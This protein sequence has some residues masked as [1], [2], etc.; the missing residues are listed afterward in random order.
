MDEQK[1]AAADGV[2]AFQ[3]VP[4]D[5][6]YR[7][8]SQLIQQADAGERLPSERSIAESIGVSR[9]AVR[10]AFNRLHKEGRI[11][12]KIGSGS[13]VQA[14]HGGAS[15]LS[16]APDVGMIDV[17]ELRSLLEPGIAELA[18]ARAR[19]DDLRKIVQR[20]AAME[21]ASDHTAFKIAGYQFQLAVAEATRNPLIVAVY[22]MLIEAREQLGWHQLQNLSDTAETRHR[23][24]S[25]TNDFVDALSSRDRRKAVEIARQRV[26]DIADAAMGPRPPQSSI[27]GDI[28]D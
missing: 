2:P 9:Q 14:A 13:Y 10:A 15:R 27:G 24:V 19:A 22:Q 21:A 12:R 6:A 18:T 5:I 4:A 17:I 20:L 7:H 23:L 8:V 26:R 1:A 25:R 28:N 16:V 3:A 11:S